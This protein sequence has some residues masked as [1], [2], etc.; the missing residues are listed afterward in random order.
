[1]T[2]NNEADQDAARARIARR[3]KQRQRD[4]KATRLTVALIGAHGY[5]AVVC[6]VGVVGAF[7]YNRWVALA[8]WLL[9]CVLSGL[10]AFRLWT[11]P[12]PSEALS[13]WAAVISILVFGGSA[14]GVF[15]ILVN[16]AALILLWCLSVSEPERDSTPES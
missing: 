9:A 7:A 3:V 14:G 15:S 12:K 6:A 8:A 1:M 13:I 5:T 16:V 11:S 4:D 2:N 10:A